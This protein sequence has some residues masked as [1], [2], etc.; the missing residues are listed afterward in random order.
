MK[1][2]IHFVDCSP[3]GG[4]WFAGFESD[5]GVGSYARTPVEALQD[6]MSFNDHDD[7]RV[8]AC[9]AEIAKRKVAA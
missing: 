2:N 4:R 3:I 5:E 7:E 9:E 6:L 1:I 8:A